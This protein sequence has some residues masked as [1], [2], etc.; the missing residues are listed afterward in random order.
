MTGS[1]RPEWLDKLLAERRGPAVPFPDEPEWPIS[2]QVG[3]IRAARSMDGE[4]GARLVL[5][6]SVGEEDHSWANTMLLSNLIEVSTSRDVRLDPE[7]TNL[8]FP[9]LVETDIVGPM[10][11]AQFGPRLG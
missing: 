4:G 6:T 3:E 2:V 11:G 7:E 8:P 1:S 10:F 9:V 5:V